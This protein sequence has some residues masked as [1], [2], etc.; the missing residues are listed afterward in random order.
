MKDEGQ[1]TDAYVL[2]KRM[3]QA[4]GREAAWRARKICPQTSDHNHQKADLWLRDVDAAR[5]QEPRRFW[6]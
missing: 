5:E 1:T 3:R 6:V 2:I 4:D